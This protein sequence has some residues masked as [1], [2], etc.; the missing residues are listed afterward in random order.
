MSRKSI[1]PYAITAFLTLASACSKDSSSTGPTGSTL[2]D[3]EFDSM[4]DAMSAIGVFFPVS[5]LGLQPAI[6]AGLALQTQSVPIDETNACPGGG[7][8][9][10]QGSVTVTAAGSVSGNLNQTGSNCKGTA[11]DGTTFTFNTNGPLATALT[12]TENATTGAVNMTFRETG[13]MNWAKTAKSGG[14]SLELNVNLGISASGTAA[15]GVSGTVC[16]RSVN[17]SF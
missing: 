9:R 10:V 11:S 14:C 13:K 12:L 15:G 6:S 1:L 8:V 2:T 4:M 16:G 5:G 3:V 17:D 7:T